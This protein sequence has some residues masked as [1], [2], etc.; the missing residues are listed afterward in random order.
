MPKPYEFKTT[1]DGNV[2]TS[3]GGVVLSTDSVDSAAT[4]YGYAAPKVTTSVPSVLSS[5]AG[6]DLVAS[7][8]K[9][10]NQLSSNP[11]TVQTPTDTTK[12]TDASKT[13]AATG[14]GGQSGTATPPVATEVK[15]INPDTGQEVTFQNP[16]LNK[17]NIQAYLSGG[18]SVSEASG[19]IPSWL[20][21]GGVQT[22]PTQLQKLQGEATD[23]QN[24]LKSLT[25]NLTKFTISDAD[26]AAQV[27][28]ITTLWDSRIADMN[29]VNQA[30]EGSINTLGIRLG[31]RF[32]GG[33]G[34]TFGGII[35]EEERQGIVRIGELEGQKQAAIAAAKQAAMSQNW[36]VYSKQ[37]DIAEKAYE[38]KVK[39]I[40]TLQKATA[41]Q[42]KLI[43]DSLKEQEKAE[44]DHFTKP[45][46]D[47][48]ESAAKNDAPREVQDAINAAESVAD[49]IA[50]AGSYLQD[51]PTSGIVGEYLFYTKQAK[52]AG[53]IPVDFNAYQDMDANRKKSIA[54]AG[55]AL[56]AGGLSNTTLSKVLQVSGQFDN[57][58]VV[59]DYNTTATQVNYIESLGNLPTD[60]IARV[61]AFAKVMDPNSAVR[62]G[63]YDTVQ[64]YAQAVLQAAGLKAKRVFTN[65]GFLTDEA[66][67][68]LQSTLRSR[69]KTQEKTYNNV[70]DEYGRR[71]DK[72]TGG[73]DGKEYVTD[74]GK[75]Y[76]TGEELV[77]SESESQ[78]AVTDYGT[79][80][81]EARKQILSLA[82]VPQESLGG[83]AYT[84][85]EIAQILGI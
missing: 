85:A 18:Y 77:K 66:R 29:R 24:E 23:A 39:E 79:A 38:T 31:S 40:E 8:T 25:D 63:E 61:Y 64:Q 9:K 1:P 46:N 52:A 41:D 71:I 17:A 6:A 81:P 43:A 34:G 69:L 67:G 59:K 75:G 47:I 16:D 10:L 20:Q 36:S 5:Q 7:Q 84:W 65:S 56:G 27:Q 2:Q 73:S 62:E 58:Q 55:A 51:V 54:R 76:G 49:A 72:I 26:L 19:S 21:P 78:Q 70:Y 48:L 37:I 4:R 28:G 83:R 68:F 33:K 50:A 30:R 35:S 42:N 60:D 3:Q 45:K 82:G 11:A 44:Y 14:T 12:T 15:L 32:A 57:E 22:Q 13:G 53:Q 80:N 74:Y